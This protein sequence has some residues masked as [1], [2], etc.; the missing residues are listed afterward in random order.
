VY[1]DSFNTGFYEPWNTYNGFRNIDDWGHLIYVD[2]SVSGEIELYWDQ[3]GVRF[4]VKN[5]YSSED[6]LQEALDTDM[7]WLQDRYGTG[8]IEM[9][10]GFD[11]AP[12]MI[13]KYS[14]K[15]FNW[16]YTATPNQIYA[17]AKSMH[18]DV[19]NLRWQIEESIDG[20]YETQSA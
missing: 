4:V 18:E 12:S 16:L 13:I 5:I 11:H 15:P 8:S 1:F 10:K 9:E 20:P 2:C 17:F 19:W 14:D 7:R 6:A 3:K